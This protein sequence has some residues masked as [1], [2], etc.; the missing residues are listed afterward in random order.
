MLYNIWPFNEL[1][2]RCVIPLKSSYVPKSGLASS[3]LTIQT[4]LLVPNAV[5]L[6]PSVSLSPF[7]SQ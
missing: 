4:I 6:A 2:E 3:V 1:S 5:I 7:P